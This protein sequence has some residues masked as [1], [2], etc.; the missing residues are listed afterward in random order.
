MGVYSIE[1]ELKLLEFGGLGLQGHEVVACF[2]LAVFHGKLAKC[3]WLV[4]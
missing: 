1:V 4:D 3:C 2:T